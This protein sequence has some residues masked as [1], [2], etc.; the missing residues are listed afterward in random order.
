M[1]DGFEALVQALLGIARQYRH[2]FA[3]DDRPGVYLRRHE[4]NAAARYGY[5]RVERLADGVQSAKHGNDATVLR[6]VRAARAV[7]RDERRVNV[8][9]AVGKLC[10]EVRAENAH[11]ACQH[12]QIYLEEV[13]P[14]DE[15]CLALFAILPVE[16]ER[17]QVV[18]VR[19]FQAIGVDSVTRH[20]GNLDAGQFVAFDGIDHGLQVRTGAGDQ[21]SEPQG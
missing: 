5:A 20:Q 3:A 11:P 16:I 2:L 1:F 6:G 10:L 19:A 8:D 21:H 17:L 18:P 4:V 9:D 14:G 13:E 15:G 7:V 12:D